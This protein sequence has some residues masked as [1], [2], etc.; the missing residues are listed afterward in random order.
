[1]CKI[2]WA[3]DIQIV[4]LKSLVIDQNPPTISGCPST[5]VVTAS[6][7]TSSAT[8]SW[9]AP[10]TSDAEG[11]ASITS[12]LSPGVTLPVGIQLVTYTA[13][14]ESGLKAFCSFNIIVLASG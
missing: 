8:V 14:D 9:T 7:G 10:T 5:L 6:A 2:N 11:T 12:N 4:L 13:A 1:M 3:T